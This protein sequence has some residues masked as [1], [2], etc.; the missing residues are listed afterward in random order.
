MLTRVSPASA[1]AGA[2]FGRS[3]PL[4]V[5]AMASSPVIARRRPMWSMMPRRTSGSPPVSRI[6]L[7]PSST[8]TAAKRSISSKE[9]TSSWE[10]QA[11][12]SAGMQ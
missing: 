7:M 9:R 8:A 2:I 6:L 11:T 1:S 4:V 10:R 12:P 3:V 5:S